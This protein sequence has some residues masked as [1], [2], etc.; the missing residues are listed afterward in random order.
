MTKKKRYYPNNWRAYKDSPDQFFLPL[1]FDEFMDWKVAGWQLPSSVACMIRE[2]N[3]RTG[4][5]TEHVY[6]RTGD[7]KNKARAIMD[8]GESEF[9]VVTHD[10]VHQVYPQY[11]EEYYDYEES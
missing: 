7:A 3:H 9:C 4:K 1:A 5:V 8:I 10:A 11:E 2:T 6:S